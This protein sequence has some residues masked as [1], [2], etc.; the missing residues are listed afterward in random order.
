MLLAIV[1]VCQS[2]SVTAAYAQRSIAQAACQ[3]PEVAQSI[4]NE[5]APAARRQARSATPVTYQDVA[6]AARARH[7]LASHLETKSISGRLTPGRATHTARVEIRPAT[8][9]DVG[10]PDHSLRWASAP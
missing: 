8:P 5:A 2:R 10:W 9:R 3:R 6:R 4:G 7:N 1:G